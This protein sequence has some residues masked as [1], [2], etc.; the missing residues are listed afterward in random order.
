MT[1]K[2]K[3]LRAAIRDLLKSGP[4]GAGDRVF[5][6][7][8]EAYASDELPA[9][10][11]YTKSDPVA[12]KRNESPRQYVREARVVV[13]CVLSTPTE[14]LPADDDVDEFC[15]Q[16]E[17]LILPRLAAL[18]IAFELDYGRTG[19]EGMETVVQTLEGDLPLAGGRL[20]FV[21]AYVQEVSE[22]DLAECDP[23]LRTH[24]EHDLGSADTPEVEDDFPMPQG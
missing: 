8:S 1:V 24:V 12:D 18:C 6:N 4:T 22:V 15:Q 5:T 2:R 20:V 9:I 13:D 17:D 3:E 23:W 16:I 14:D 11:V 7:R 10:A 21:F 19:Y